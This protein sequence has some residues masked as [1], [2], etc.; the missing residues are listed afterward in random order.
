VIHNGLQLAGMPFG[1]QRTDALC[2]VG[3]VVPEKGVV[4]AIEIAKATGRPL[5]MAAKAGPTQV[6]RDY[7][8]NVFTTALEDAGSLVE[9]L[10]ELDEPDR[11]LLFAESYATLMPGPWPEPFGLVLIESLACGTPVIARRIGALPEILREGV[12]GFFGDDVQAM[13]YTVD[14]VAGLDRAEIRESVIDRFSVERMTD[15]YEALYRAMLEVPSGGKPGGLVGVGPSG[16]EADSD[17]AG[18]LAAR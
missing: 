15:R 12:D 3:R 4:E 1:K 10:G 17:R 9:F 8:E 5:R 16:R 11:D 7:F 14:R 2:F 18:E 6:E 13:A